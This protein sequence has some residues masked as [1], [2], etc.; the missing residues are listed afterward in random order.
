MKKCSKCGL[1]QQLS[2]FY[3]HGQRKDGGIIRRP[4]CKA[5]VKE[6]NKASRNYDREE[7]R[8]ARRF[9]NLTIDE[10][11]SYW[12]A[13]ECGICGS[14]DPKDRRQKFHIDHCHETGRVRGA[15]CSNCN[16]GLGNLQDSPDLLRKAAEYLERSR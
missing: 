7:E 8:H 9:Y 10:A 2:E 1:E 12:H 6:R 14:T 13:D 15:L 16:L 11:R 4:D 5:C 3:V